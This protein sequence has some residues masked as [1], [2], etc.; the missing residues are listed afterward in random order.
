MISLA[1]HTSHDVLPL[2]WSESGPLIDVQLV[3]R[4]GDGATCIRLASRLEQAHPR[5]EPK[6]PIHGSR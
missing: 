5:K 4:F 6:P 3:A 1:G 2:H